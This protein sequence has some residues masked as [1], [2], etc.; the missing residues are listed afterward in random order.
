MKPSLKPAIAFYYAIY[1]ITL[2]FTAIGSF[3][4]PTT[5]W[6]EAD[7]TLV[8]TIYSLLVFYLLISIPFSLKWLSINNK[9]AKKLT[10]ENEKIKH[11]RRTIYTVLSI[12][13][14]GLIASLVCF[15]LFKEKSCIYMAGIEIIVLFFCKPTERKMITD[16][17]ADEEIELPDQDRT[18][19]DD[20]SIQA[21]TKNDK[22]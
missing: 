4:A 15:Y 11:Y 1:A 13:A 3:Y 5:P 21:N 6:I 8:K 20:E 19:K 12:T 17:L 16:L 14:F 2:T 9:K 10:D 7:S 18:S 22:I